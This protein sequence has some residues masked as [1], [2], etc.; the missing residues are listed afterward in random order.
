[1]SEINIDLLKESARNS[2][3]ELIVRTEDAY[4][5]RIFDIASHIVSHKEIHVVLIAG[6]SGSGKTTTANLLSDA[7]RAR[8]RESMVVSLDNFYRNQDSE[9]YPRDEEGR[10]DPESPYALNIQE[11]RSTLS[12]IAEQREFTLPRYD[13]K[14][15]ARA[16]QKKYSPITSGVVIVEGLHALNPEI[17]SAAAR[18]RIYGIFISVSTNINKN[19]KRI[20]SGRKIRFLRRLVRDSIYRGADAQKTLGMWQGVLV[21]EDKYL[22]PYR[23]LADISFD[24]FHLFELF[25]MKPYADRLITKEIASINEYAMTV[26]SALSEFIE[27]DEAL[28]PENSLIREFIPGGRYESVY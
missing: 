6:P 21:G 28:V 23:D 13:F 12:D 1:M 17:L 24:T 3:E 18:E 8:G 20:L 14:T 9:D 15:G 4:H 10:V 26:Y 7:I 5:K 22:Y 27:I 2:V 25:V 19:G 11:I 16:E